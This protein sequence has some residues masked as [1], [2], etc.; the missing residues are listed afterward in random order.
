M[1]PPHIKRRILGPQ[2]SATHLPQYCTPTRDCM[3]NRTEGGMCAPQGVYEPVVCPP[4]LYCPSNAVKPIFCPKG[5]YCPIGSKE[6]RKCASLSVCPSNSM[7]HFDLTPL[8]I[9]LFVDIML[10]TALMFRSLQKRFIQR[11]KKPVLTIMRDEGNDVEMFIESLKR[12]HMS[13]PLGLS[14]DFK[15]LEF[16]SKRPQKVSIVKELSGTIKQGSLWGIM[17][18]SGCG[19]CRSS[20]FLK[21]PCTHLFEATFIKLLMGKISGNKGRTTVNGISIRR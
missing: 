8:I 6:P 9:L 18:A 12:C 19:K 10:V 21:L 14:F 5:F 17:G 4:G 16:R 20:T 2:N 1:R 3:I 15:S 7:R 13:P 11:R